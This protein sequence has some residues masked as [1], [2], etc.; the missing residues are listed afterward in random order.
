[1]KAAPA[2]KAF[3][4]SAADRKRRIQ[5]WKQLEIDYGA[6]KERIK[7]RLAEADKKAAESAQSPRNR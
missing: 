3:P 7:Q 5:E 4:E 6:V 1:M 2:A